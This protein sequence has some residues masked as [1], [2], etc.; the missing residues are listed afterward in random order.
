MQHVVRIVV[1]SL[2]VLNIQHVYGQEAV[3]ANSVVDSAVDS[4]ETATE[5]PAVPTEVQAKVTAQEVVDGARTAVS[6]SVEPAVVPVQASLKNGRSFAL[7]VCGHPGDND[8]LQRF[9]ESMT[10]VHDGLVA[11]YGV[12]AAHIT[13]LFG[14]GPDGF[15]ALAIDE[16]RAENTNEGA[17]GSDSSEA[18][19]P[20]WL[21]AADAATSANL[22]NS[23]DELKNNITADDTLWVIVMGHSNHDRGRTWFNL[24]GPD[25]Q[26]NQFAS[27]FQDVK[28]R[29]QTYLITIPASGYFVKP[30]SRSDRTVIAATEPGLEINET[31]FPHALADLMNK[32]AGEI[33]DADQD[34]AISLFDFYIAITTDVASRYADDGFLSTEHAVIDDNGD[35]RGTELQGH[36][37]T[38]K[39]G[40][41]PKTRQRKTLLKGRDGFR[42][43]T[44][45][46]SHDVI[47]AD[48][49]EAEDEAEAESKD[50]SDADSEDDG[51]DDSEQEVSAEA[52]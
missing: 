49:T 36:F 31:L 15:E 17:N 9:A 33:V 29:Q 39:L 25:M 4:A 11:N 52:A 42:S 10:S 32:P 45:I 14:E 28:S 3:D 43:T 41:L 24:A 1:L 12:P 7:L 21:T 51:E 6:G 8:R 30:L 2:V 22:Q 5:K 35:R 37:L 23:I 20:T 27:L 50:E 48:E 47:V 13:T 44:M 46:L 19:L 38:E 26:Q 16:D 18:S 40:G 34:G